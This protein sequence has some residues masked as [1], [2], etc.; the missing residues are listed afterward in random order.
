ML[1]FCAGLEGPQHRKKRTAEAEEQHR[2]EGVDGRATAAS[3]YRPRHPPNDLRIDNKTVCNTAQ[4]YMGNYHYQ[5]WCQLGL[6]V[7]IWSTFC[8]VFMVHCVKLMLRIFEF[9]VLLSD[10]F[11]YRQNVTSLKRFTRYGHYAGE[12]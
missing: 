4:K 2:E 7:D 9:G 12:M 11:V 1:V 5:Y 3:K 10:C 6:T 8:G